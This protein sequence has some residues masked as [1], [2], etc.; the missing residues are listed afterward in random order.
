MISSEVEIRERLVLLRQEFGNLDAQI[1]DRMLNN[2]MT[3]LKLGHM[4][5]RH[6][7]L[8]ILIEKLEDDLIPDILA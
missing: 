5:K 8:K 7:E 6:Y 3:D 4:L 1:D 2:T